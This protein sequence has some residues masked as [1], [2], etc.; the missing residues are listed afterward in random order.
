MASNINT[1]K[2]TFNLE[3]IPAFTVGKNQTV[4]LQP[5]D[6]KPPY[7]CDISKGNL[8]A[9]LNFSKEG[10]LSGTATAPNDNNP[11]TVWFRVTDSLKA[12]GTTAYEV[13]VIAGTSKAA[14]ARKAYG[15]SL[16]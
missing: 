13:T 14:K 16:G 6:G 2:P 12:S 8:P 7:T 5:T 1:T 11:P 15:K 9:G 10:K 4:D 3:D